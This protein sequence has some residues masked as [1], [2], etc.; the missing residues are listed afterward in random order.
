M[1]AEKGG[2]PIVQTIYERE[3]G[4]RSWKEFMI[5]SLVR[6]F[7]LFAEEP[8]IQLFGVYLAFVYGTIY[9]K[10]LLIPSFLLRKRVFF[11]INNV[12]LI[13]VLTTIPLVYT[14]LYHERIGIVGLHYISLVSS[15]LT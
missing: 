4:D 6:P 2:H 7:V 12:I 9:R 14:E 3:K 1:D 10:S 13:V 15:G 5:H 11:Y 8:I